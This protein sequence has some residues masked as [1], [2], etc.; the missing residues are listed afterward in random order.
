MATVLTTFTQDCDIYPLDQ[1]KQ[2]PIE[3]KAD[4]EE[5][6]EE[7][8][9]KSKFEW[10]SSSDEENDG[11]SPAKDDKDDKDARTIFVTGL[12][13]EVDEEQLQELFSQFGEITNLDCFRKS[14]I[15][16]S[17]AFIEY[18]RPS[19]AKKASQAELS[20]GDQAITVKV[21]LNETV[22][23][24]SSDKVEGK[25]QTYNPL[26]VS[27]RKKKIIKNV[28]M[29]KD[30]ESDEEVDESD[31]EAGESESG[32]EEDEEEEEGNQEGEGENEAEPQISRSRSRS[33]EKAAQS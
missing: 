32:D 1:E 27:D 2:E 24:I 30:D 22:M 12:P 33:R 17:R 14:G 9:S 4:V 20:L 15:N 26:F 29:S 5:E 23:G 31:E 10:M 7:E 25:I 28:K 16:Q 19:S 3:K 6:E 11:G 21:G 18:T 13:A 8:P